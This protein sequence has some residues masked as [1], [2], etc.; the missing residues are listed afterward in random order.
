MARAS[1][2]QTEGM[3]QEKTAPLVTAHVEAVK[4]TQR[5]SVLGDKLVVMHRTRDAAEQKVS[6]LAAKAVTTNQ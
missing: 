2:S 6:I 3:A 1:T 4:A 5:V